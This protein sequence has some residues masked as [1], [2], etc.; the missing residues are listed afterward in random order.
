MDKDLLRLVIIAIG[1]IVVISMVVWSLFK[2]R[3]QMRD[4]DFYDKGNPLDNIDESLI[5]KTENDDFDV[6]P[7][8]SALDDDSTLDPISIASQA[9]EVTRPSKSAKP[10]Q[11]V[12]P[13][14][15]KQ[16]KKPTEEKKADIPEIIQFSI[17]AVAEDGFKGKDLV[18][19]F[20][21][22]G[23]EYGSVKV[24]ERVDKQKRVG[25]AVA[26]MVE[27]GTFPDGILESYTTPGLVFFF[28]AHELEKPLPVFDNL[29][30]TIDYLAS[31]LDGSIW[32]QNREPL[33]DETV[34]EIR[35]LLS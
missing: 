4:I 19:A 22:V 2:N 17:V 34:Q 11:P 20:E 23:L 27:P 7:L 28:Q 29:M 32:G 13:V 5:L 25:F 16:I 6:V 9:K 15:A 8:G 10:V 14:Q 3:N 31:T 21:T 12:Q 24:F 26:S 1:A 33:T 30:K 35:V 18:K